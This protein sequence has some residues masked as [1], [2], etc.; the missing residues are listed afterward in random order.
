MDDIVRSPNVNDIYRCLR[1]GAK[2]Y[3]VVEEYFT[4]ERATKI[5][6]SHGKDPMCF[7]LYMWDERQVV[8]GE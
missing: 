5:S 1:C 6:Y 2:S 3:A 4:A 7:V 8:P